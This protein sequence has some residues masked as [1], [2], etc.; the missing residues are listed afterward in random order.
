MHMDDSGMAKAGIPT[1]QCVGSGQE[2]RI[3]Q[4]ILPERAA[5]P[6]SRQAHDG[7]ATVVADWTRIEAVLE[8]DDGDARARLRR[9]KR[10]A[11]GAGVIGELRLGDMDDVE[12][13]HGVRQ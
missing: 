4:H 8:S 5:S 1:H 3:F 10:F 6:S 7:D 13:A 12:R 2:A 11:S 9:D